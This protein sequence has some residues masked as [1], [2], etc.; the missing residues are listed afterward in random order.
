VVS[1]SWR[2]GD[3]GTSSSP[4]PSHT[5]GA[6]GTYTVQLTVT[7]DKGAT[8]SAS[9]AV[10]VTAPPPPN[11]P[12]VADFSPSCTNLQCSFTDGSSD[13]DGRVVSWSWRFGDGGTA[14]SPNP[15]HTYGSA[16]TYT[17]QLTVTDDKGA[18]GSTSQS[19]TVTAPPPPNRPPNVIAGDAQRV[20]LG[21]LFT[22]QGASFSDPDHDGPWTVTLDWGDGRSDTFGA[23]EGSIGGSHSYPVTLL[24]GDYTLTITVVDAHGARSSAS[25]TVHVVVA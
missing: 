8:G 3:G 19:V 15:S 17:V 14:A 4:N 7:D 22:L 12:P 20:L 24:G 5:Y 11:Q 18:T 9:H 6:A 13:P 2:F 10:T 21:L 25:K 23:S 16:G 1:W